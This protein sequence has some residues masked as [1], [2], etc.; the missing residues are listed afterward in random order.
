MDG[1][2]DT[3]DGDACRDLTLL[4][5]EIK[6]AKSE[7]KAAKVREE[8]AKMEIMDIMGGVEKIIVPGAKISWSTTEYKAQPEKITP[9]KP[10]HTGR[11]FSVKEI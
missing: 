2:D 7:I 1:P 5:N 3:F 9:A 4:A 8:E 10:A 11:R 6:E